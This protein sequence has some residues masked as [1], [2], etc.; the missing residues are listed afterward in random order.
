MLTFKNLNLT[1]KQA[2][3]IAILIVIL[4]ALIAF[5]YQLGNI[6]LIDKTEPMFV[7]AARQM[8][9]TGDWLTPYWNDATRFDKPPLIYWLMAISFKIFGINEMAARLPSALFGLLTVLL[10]FYL[11]YLVNQKILITQENPDLTNHKNLLIATIG[12]LITIL[13]PAWIAWSR[14]GVSDMLLSSNI[15]LALLS[16]FIGYIHHQEKPKIK[17]FWYLA[18]YVFSALAVLTKGPIGILFPVIIIASFSIYVKQWKPVLRELKL[19]LGMPLFIIIT[20]PWFILIS[21]KHGSEYIDTFF[22]Y[23]NFERFTTVVSNHPGPWYYFFPVLFGGLIPWSCYLPLAIIRLKFWQRNYYIEQNRE[24]QLSLFALIW[25]VVIFTFFSISVT[26]LPSYILPVLPAEA[27]LITFTWQE[28]I[29]KSKP[30]F[31]T[32]AYNLTAIFNIIILIAMA[33]AS[34]NLPNF[35]GNNPLTPNLQKDLTLSPT[36]EIASILWILMAIVSIIL[37]FKTQQ[38]SYLWLTNALGFLIFIPTFLL[39]NAKIYD[40]DAQLP[41]RK[42]GLT[43]QQM[44]QTQEEV[45][46]IGFIRPSLVFYSQHPVKF[47]NST[48][49]ALSYLNHATNQGANSFLIIAQPEKIAELNLTKNSYDLIDQQGVYQLIR[50]RKTVG[51]AMF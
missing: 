40:L 27:I 17:T 49:E 38:K 34:F 4:T 8:V 25:L 14:T 20:V 5:F 6:G 31:P 10:V 3:I 37:L 51:L 11:I 28:I 39:P 23:H 29:T 44:K 15:S 22:G 19:H 2:T 48:S 13:N 35:L 33:W 32:W 1:Q 9:I 43:I 30:N 47:F 41:L 26:K 50:L 36:P 21:L 12:A 42:L 45:L 46:L 16:F 24:N 7:E 18:F